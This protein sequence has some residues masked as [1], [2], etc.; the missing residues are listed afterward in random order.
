MTM[1]RSKIKGA[2]T[3]AQ[4]FIAKAEA[5]LER[6]NAENE[7]RD[8]TYQCDHSWGSAETGALRRASLDLTR[9]LAELRK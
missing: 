7:R 8:T 4:R 6:I 5:A 2:I 3:E 1:T 9:N